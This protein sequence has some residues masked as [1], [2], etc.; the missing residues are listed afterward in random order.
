MEITK[1]KMKNKEITNKNKYII[2]TYKNIKW[3]IVLLLC[4]LII[5]MIKEMLEMMIV[6]LIACI[7]FLY[8]K[9]VY[10]KKLNN[11]K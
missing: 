10:K 6:T 9:Q 11:R 2:L 3:I 4:S 1:R 7:Y 8:L 5:F